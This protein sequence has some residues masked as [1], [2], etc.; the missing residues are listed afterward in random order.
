L[1]RRPPQ[2][3]DRQPLEPIFHQYRVLL[4]P[5]AAKP[6]MIPSGR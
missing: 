5:T 3:V 1:D 6:Q 4:N 2:F